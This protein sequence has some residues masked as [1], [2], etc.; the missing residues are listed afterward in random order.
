MLWIPFEKFEIQTTLDSYR[1][2]QKLGEMTE[3]PTFKVLLWPPKGG[4]PFAGTVD[5]PDF[6]IRRIIHYRNSFLPV[7]CGRAEGSRLQITARLNW[8][9][10]LFM[11]LWLGIVL[12]VFAL[13]F[14]S[15]V[16][17]NPPAPYGGLRLISGGMLLFGY[18]LCVLPFYFEL[19]KAKRILEE[20]LR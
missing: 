17:Q 1:I 10:A 19:K 7:L 2:L 9:V 11:G 6:K 16:E 15:A 3:K 13:S 5:G 14:P 20:A 12:F 8:F 18:F 4:K